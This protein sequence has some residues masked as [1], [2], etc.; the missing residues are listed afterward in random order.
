MSIRANGE[1][2]RRVY[3][4]A[5]R[6]GGEYTGKRRRKAVSIRVNGEGRR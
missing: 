3:R 5:E 6:E 2:R 1:G 4:R